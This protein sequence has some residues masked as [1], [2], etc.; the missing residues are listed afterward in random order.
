MRKKFDKK[1]SDGFLQIWSHNLSVFPEGLLYPA[2]P[3]LIGISFCQSKL[4]VRG[5]FLESFEKKKERKTSV[6][7]STV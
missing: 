3:H 7:T 5:Y 6:K 2:S 4:N 1:K